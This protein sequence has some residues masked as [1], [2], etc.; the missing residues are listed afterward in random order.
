MAKRRKI[1]KKE[2]LA[3]KLLH[4]QTQGRNQNFC[5][6][7]YDWTK[8]NQHH[9]AFNRYSVSCNNY[10]LTVDTNLLAN[11]FPEYLDLAVNLN[12]K[13]SEMRNVI[14]EINT[15]REKYLN[16]LFTHIKDKDKVHLE[17]DLLTDGEEKMIAEYQSEPSK[18]TDLLNKIDALSQE[19]DALPKGKANAERKKNCKHNLTKSKIFIILLKDKQNGY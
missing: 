1:S 16:S 18:I 19:L 2:E 17:Y 14:D 8:I 4:D 3:Y 10:Y 12:T 6:F 11:S 9:Y 13:L 15:L 7:P 5:W